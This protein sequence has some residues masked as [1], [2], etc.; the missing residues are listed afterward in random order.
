MAEGLGIGDDTTVV[1]Y[2]H[3][4]GADGGADLVGVQLLR[5][6][7]REGAQRWMAR[8]GQ[9]PANPLTLAGPKAPAPVTF[10]PTGPTSRSSPPATSSRRPARWT[11]WWCGT[12]A[13]TPNGTSTAEN[14]R[15]KRVGHVPGAVHL[16]WFHLMDRNTHEFKP[17]RRDPAHPHRA[18]DHAGQDGILLLTGRHPC[19]AR[20][21]RTPPG[22][23]RERQE[24]RRVH[25]RVGQPGR[26]AAHRLAIPWRAG[27]AFGG[28]STA[29]RWR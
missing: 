6:Q 8:L 5:P 23:L 1:T 19:G 15:N 4:P 16:E 28:S 29:T 22:R 9:R 21:L 2:D 18:R 24:L 27:C 3:A 20:K 11:T 25:G 7:Q 17:G 13:A 10:T 14:Y 12:C 26:H